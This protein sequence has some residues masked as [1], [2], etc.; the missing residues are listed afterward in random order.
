V[1][2]GRRNRGMREGSGRV[3]VGVRGEKE[4]MERKRKREVWKQ[5]ERGKGEG[6]KKVCRREEINKGI[7]IN[8]GKLTNTKGEKVRKRMYSIKEETNK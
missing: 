3:E 4:E 2:K 1:R 7:C 5:E 6:R 8:K